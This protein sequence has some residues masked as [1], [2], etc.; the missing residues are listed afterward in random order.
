MDILKSN[1]DLSCYK[2]FYAVAV[3]ESFSKAASE[4]YISQPAVSY[5]I[6]RLEEDL[7]TRLFIR[8]N[9]GIKLTDDGL[10][11][12]QYVESAFDY[13][14]A[15]HKELIE[16][17]D[18]L[19]GE[20]SI[21]TYSHVGSFLLPKL[22]KKFLTKYPKV[23]FNIYNSTGTEMRELFKE[24]KIDILVLYYPIFNSYEDVCEQKILTCESCFFGKKE[25]LEDIKF[26]S[27]STINKCQLLLPLKG[28]T[29]G[30]ALDVVF[31]N[32]NMM[33]VTNIRLYSAELMINLVKE[34]LG[35]GWTLREYI[36]TE[37]ENKIFYEI[38]TDVNL[39]KI[40]FGLAYD[41]KVITKSALAFA[42]FLINELDYKNESL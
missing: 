2:T 36:K 30:N 32:N 39:P 37:L 5:N 6:K 41:K 10:K 8:M 9:K 26:L 22:I 21:G 3:Y 13:L 1:I 19:S 42:E 33:L 15:G 12:K 34:G 24:K 7:N 4:L 35:I 28:F 27:S 25:Q 31:K 29:T 20:I 17:N 11:L 40:E 38:P 23:K 16:S 18:Q 14:I